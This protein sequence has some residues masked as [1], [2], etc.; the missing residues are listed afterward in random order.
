MII[1]AQIPKVFALLEQEREDRVSYRVV[2]VIA[3]GQFES[4]Q[5]FQ[6]LFP[7]AD[8]ATL[9]VGPERL[10]ILNYQKGLALFSAQLTAE[11]VGAM[12]RKLRIEH[13]KSNRFTLITSASF[14]LS[15]A[16]TIVSDFYSHIS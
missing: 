13:R 9:W 8:D 10:Q 6:V 2:K 1:E 4:G 16:L 3:S 5:R 15:V 12:A 7:S 14:C 11:N